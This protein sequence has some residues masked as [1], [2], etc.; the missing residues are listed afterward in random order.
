[1]PTRLLDALVRAVSGFRCRHN[2]ACLLVICLSGSC[3]W[4]L[5]TGRCSWARTMTA[6]CWLAGSVS[7]LARPSGGCRG[8][9]CAATATRLGH[10]S[11]FV[12]GSGGVRCAATGRGAG[13][14]VHGR[15]LPGP[16]HLVGEGDGDG[17]AGVAAVPAR[18]RADAV[19][20]AGAVPG[21]AGWRLASLPRGLDAAVVEQ[22]LAVLRPGDGGRA[23]RLRDLDVLARLGLRGAEVAGLRLGDIDWRA[24]EVTVTA[25]QPGR[26]AAA[27]GEVGEAIGPI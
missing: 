17:A 18:V 20:L 26:P 10:V 21:V 11:G 7:W 27:A 12:A 9:Q 22:L 4:F 16:Q 6:R 5:Q 25:R 1:M 23:A 8:R 15:V 2:P 24:G 14:R 3:Q 19:P 13:D